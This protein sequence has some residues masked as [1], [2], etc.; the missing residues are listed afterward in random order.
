[1]PVR[2]RQAA[3][4]IR[5]ALYLDE[6]PREHIRRR[7]HRPYLPPQA[8]RRRRARGRW[9]AVVLVLYVAVILTLAWLLV[10]LLSVR[11]EVAG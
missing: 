8:V 7:S 1:M 3:P 9:P 5:G 4:R 11:V 6:R 10:T 2:S